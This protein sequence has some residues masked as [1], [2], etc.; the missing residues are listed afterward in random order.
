MTFS[1]AVGA[2]VVLGI[3]ALVAIGLLFGGSQIAGALGQATREG[4]ALF[5]ISA[6]IYVALVAM[7][8][9]AAF[10]YLSGGIGI[11]R[12]ESEGAEKGFAA[13][14]MVL[15]MVGIELVWSIILA[16]AVAQRTGTP[17]EKLGG[18]IGATIFFAFL[19]SIM[20]AALLFWCSKYGP[21]LPN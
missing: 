6:L 9:F 8:G 19:R 1:G 20:P 15:T 4:G 12:G 14:T 17:S 13:S 5:W 2:M 7:T 11:L 18:I 21:R 10:M 16:I 3:V